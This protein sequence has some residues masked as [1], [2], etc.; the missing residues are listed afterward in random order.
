VVLSARH[1]ADPS[2]GPEPVG[3]SYPCRHRGCGAGRGP[4]DAGERDR[5]AGR[6][7]LGEH[8]AGAVR[9]PAERATGELPHV[10]RAL[11]EVLDEQVGG[12]G[13]CGRR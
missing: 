4:G 2:G 7:G 9:H 11:L 5:V 13:R 3:R 1:D 8:G 10:D 12:V 6:I